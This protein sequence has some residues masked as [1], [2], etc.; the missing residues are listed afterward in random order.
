MT[1]PNKKNILVI[2]GGSVGAIAALNLEVGGLAV[3]TLV[4]RSNYEAVKANGYDI[5]SCDHGTLKSW[6]PHIGM[7]ILTVSPS[8]LRICEIWHQI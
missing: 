2:G 4:L 7:S 1:D 8:F 3:V 5:E 6:K